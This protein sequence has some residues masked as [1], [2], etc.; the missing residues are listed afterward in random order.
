MAVEQIRD[1]SGQI[2]TL[3]SIAAELR[4]GVDPNDIHA[5]LRKA[6]G[7][8]LPAKFQ[9]VLDTAFAQLGSGVR[10]ENI[11]FDRSLGVTSP[12]TTQERRAP[13]VADQVAALESA[14]EDTLA[15][16]RDVQ[17]SG[18]DTVALTQRIDA[19]NA[20][21]IEVQDGTVGPQGEVLP[22]VASGSAR[23]Y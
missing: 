6:P 2:H 23:Q 20:R 18:G 12:P 1:A 4:A 9:R 8:A 17:R 19:I 3:P 15:E 10:P 14:K 5:R 13:T 22:D 11:Q 21:I 16:A 7:A